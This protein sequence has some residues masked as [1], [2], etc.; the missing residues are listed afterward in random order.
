MCVESC[1]FARQQHTRGAYII[2][3]L[4]Q[5]IHQSYIASW[6]CS[7]VSGH[8]RQGLHDRF[9]INNGHI[10]LRVCRHY[11]EIV[12]VQ[13]D[14]DQD[15]VLAL[16]ED[17]IAFVTCFQMTLCKNVNGNGDK[18]EV[19]YLKMCG[20]YYRNLKFRNMGTVDHDSESKI[21]PG[22]AEGD[23]RG[24]CEPQRDAPDAPRV[25]AQLQRV[26]LRDPQEPKKM[27]SPRSHSTPR[28]AW[29]VVYSKADPPAAGMPHCC[30]MG[31]MFLLIFCGT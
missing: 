15:A 10:P 17:Y 3:A 9:N 1:S 4:R 14:S 6:C 16:G 11:G 8:H 2:S 21:F 18:T 29:S 19:F 23:G 13:R 5:A 7:S 31:C 25:G 20:D 30:Q 22:M 26:L 28:R 24:R 12:F 27:S